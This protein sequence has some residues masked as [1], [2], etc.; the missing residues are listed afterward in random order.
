VKTLQT[1]KYC[2]HLG[3][4]IILPLL[5]LGLFYVASGAQTTTKKPAVTIAKVAPPSKPVKLQVKPPHPKDEKKIVEPKVKPKTIDQHKDQPRKPPITHLTGG[6]TVQMGSD[7]RIKELHDPTR[8]LTI[9]HGLTG[10]TRV[11]SDQG[12]RRI[13]AERGGRSF[14]QRPFRYG[15]RDYAKR[16]YIY[17]GRIYDRYYA[18]SRYHDVD[19]NYYTPVRYYPTAYYGYS[20]NRWS[21][22]VPY[23][24]E[25][26]GNSWSQYYGAYFTPAQSYSSPPAWLTD[27]ML[28]TTL[29]AA[30]QA[31][32][33]AQALAA[34]PT[35]AAPMTPQVKTLITG[36]VQRQI[37]L[38]NAEAQSGAQ[39]EAS[40]SVERDFTDNVPHIFVAGNDLDVIDNGGSECSITEGDAFRL[41]E[42]PAAEAKTA[43]LVVLASKG[44]YECKIASVVA[45]GID[46]LQEMQNHMR[47]TID[48][49]LEAMRNNKALPTPPASASGPPVNSA[50]LAAAPPPDPNAATEI[51]QQ[52]QGSDQAEKT[53]M[54][55]LAQQAQAAQTSANPP[56]SPQI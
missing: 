20:Y 32:A 44:G 35:D 30:Y 33:N 16:R 42:P 24:W 50:F 9:K 39:T 2:A 56:S 29:A 45:V 36:E 26:A 22:P 37:A 40:S 52:L 10:R 3:V 43:K 27:Y 23:A 4:A 38:E 19:I 14:V 7:G 15:G 34:P 41:I 28:S 5:G 46:D 31:N 8:G 54:E 12:G 49:G 48:A 11:V 47:E 53:A 6:R 25:W 55:Q 13:V 51:N 21:T 18:Q 17:N 1:N